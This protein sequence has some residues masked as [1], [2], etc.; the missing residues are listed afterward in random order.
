MFSTDTQTVSRLAQSSVAETFKF[1]LHVLFF[2]QMGHLHHAHGYDATVNVSWILNRPDKHGRHLTGEREVGL[3][4]KHA[5]RSAPGHTSRSKRRQH[6]F[7]SRGEPFRTRRC[8]DRAEKAV[9]G[10]YVEVF[11]FRLQRTVQWEALKF[12]YLFTEIHSQKV[13][14]YWHSDDTEEKTV[15]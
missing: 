13:S 4:I 15:K 10:A 7:M 14:V 11:T 12:F 2:L 5:K 9:V 3:A 6:M 1:W 8:P